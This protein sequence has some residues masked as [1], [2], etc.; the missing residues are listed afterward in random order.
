MIAGRRFLQ[1]NGIGPG[2][3]IILQKTAERRSF[4]ILGEMAD[5]G[6]ATLEGG[7]I[8][9]VDI[10]TF[11]EFSG[12]LGGVD[13]IDLRFVPPVTAEKLNAVRSI[14]P[15]GVFLE[16]PSETR[17]TGRTMIRSYQ[18]NLSVLS[19]VS[20][21]VGMF[22][23]YSLISLHATSRRK[24]LAI[25]RSIGASRR[26][27]FWLFIAEGS[28]FGI[29]GWLLA[30]PASL[31]MTG[32]LLGY[33]S[34]TIS[35]LFARVHVEGLYLTAWE[36]F[37]SFATTLLVA[38]LAACQPAFEASRVGAREA[39][40]MREAPEAEEGSFMKRLA[41]FGLILVATVWPLS[42][43][44][45]IGAVPIPGYLA[46]FFLFLGFA[47]LSPLFLKAVGSYIPF[48]AR[49]AGGETAFLGTH[50]LKSAGSRIAISAGALIT[51]IGLFTALVIMVHSFRGTVSTWVRQ[52]INGDLYIRAKMSDLNRYRDPL[53]SELTTAL[54]GLRDIAEIV[55]YRRI[56]LTYGAIPYLLE[57]IASK[58]FIRHSGFLFLEGDPE[59]ASLALNS[60]KG[61][62]VSEVFSNQTGVRLGDRYKAVVEGKELDL[63]VVGIIRD[64]R[65][66]GGVVHCSLP[67]FEQATGDKSWT[68]ASIFLK[69]RGPGME[70]R[71]ADL[72]NNV[73]FDATD[74][75]YNL[76]AMVGSELRRNILKI[77]DE[78][79]AITTVLLCIS[80]LIAALGI[81]T[82]LTILVLERAGQFQTLRAT[83][84]STGQIRAIISWEA[85]TMV[86]LGEVVGLACGFAL[87]VLLI[88]VIN[89]QSFG[90]TFIYSVNWGD[91]AVSFPLVCATALLAALPAAQ[92]VTRQPPALAL[93]GK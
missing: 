9:I 36:I 13:R 90:W 17:E 1:R 10:S 70:E 7:N 25:L 6:L 44:P 60:G 85:V 29:A 93:R 59:Q 76:E 68:G 81:A 20:L 11:Q 12:T 47:L 33:V 8:A 86:V 48:F 55:P 26:M 74:R 50:Y 35:H 21:F 77:F 88:F 23:V 58:S 62:L 57:P 51:A 5:E 80:L 73:L 67:W 19:F 38:V 61:V 4:L 84:A 52:S 63:P 46:T 92:L 27:I 2:D 82:T 79:F 66:Q 64:Y 87:S 89:K 42:L 41:I 37:L 22:L 14:L 45:P 91:L 65:T 24:E 83:G 39:L 18:L 15:A 54:E 31:F 53:P 69:D 28:F 43:A 34:S 71:T 32:K 75:G 30:V 49:K 40:L 78:T 72:R 56:S 3:S 16:Q